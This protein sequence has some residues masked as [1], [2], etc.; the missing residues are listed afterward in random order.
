MYVEPNEISLDSKTTEKKEINSPEDSRPLIADVN[1]NV[2]EVFEETRLSDKKFGSDLNVFDNLE[3]EDDVAKPVED[4]KVSIETKPIRESIIG[5]ILVKDKPLDEFDF[6][7]E[8]STDTDDESSD[9]E[10]EELKAPLQTEELSAEHSDGEEVDDLSEIEEIDEEISQDKGSENDSDIEELSVANS[11]A[12][13]D[14]HEFVNEDSEGVSD[15]DNDAGDR[16]EEFT[17]HEIEASVNLNRENESEN[18]ASNSEDEEQDIL[19]IEEVSPEGRLERSFSTN[20]RSIQF[21]V[22]EA[23][24]DTSSI[25][26][27]YRQHHDWEALLNRSF[28]K[29]YERDERLLSVSH[30]SHA[31]HMS[32]VSEVSKMS[33]KELLEGIDIDTVLVETTE[34]VTEEIDPE[35]SNVTVVT[36]TTF[37]E[38]RRR[39]KQGRTGRGGSKAQKFM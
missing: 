26:Q 29:S 6:T 20:A 27:S 35:T 24:D 37:T 19:V 32:H 10:F 5:E 2:E 28:N 13:G 11:D 23:E 34:Y 4:P 18:D 9:N 39:T 16:F 25:T 3:K 8:D 12:E 30:M 17:E 14:T 21:S 7:K 36:H 38:V 31:S 1:K 33:E 15:E 22:S